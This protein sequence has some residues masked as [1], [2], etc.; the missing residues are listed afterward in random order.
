MGFLVSGCVL[1]YS[2]MQNPQQ[3]PEPPLYWD[4][5]GTKFNFTIVFAL[6]VTL[7]GFMQVNPFLFILGVGVATYSWLTNAKQYL[8]YPDALVI[9]YGRP[10]VKTYPF[11]T[12]A[13]LELLSLPMGD[14]LRLRMTDGRRMMLKTRDAENFRIQ[15]D[16]A[17]DAFYGGDW[18]SGQGQE[19][20]ARQQR[21]PENQLGESSGENDDVP[22]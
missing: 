4:T 6:V 1:K 8:I 3:A 10:R 18:K 20:E 7:I 11:D 19:E 17:L 5:P 9:V 2:A 12:I 22:Y 14:R 16:A 21:P 15:L 13:H